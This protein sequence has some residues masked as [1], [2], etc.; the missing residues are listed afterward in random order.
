[1]HLITLS[2]QLR[3][4]ISVTSRQQ[5]AKCSWSTATTI[6]DLDIFYILWQSND[7]QGWGSKARAD[8]AKWGKSGANRMGFSLV[9]ARFQSH[10]SSSLM[11]IHWAS[12]R[13]WSSAQLLF[14]THPPLPFYKLS[15]DKSILLRFFHRIK[16]QHHHSIL[17]DLRS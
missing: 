11:L 16:L 4:Q 10:C 6:S 5:S 8:D 13:I 15:T 3:T 17:V 1:M 14:F 9:R 7:E 2:F 12:L